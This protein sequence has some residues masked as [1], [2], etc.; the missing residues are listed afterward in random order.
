MSIYEHR[1]MDGKSENDQALYAITHVLRQVSSRHDV[2]N[3]IGPGTQTF[4]LLT[5]CYS[6]LTG[7][8]LAELR[9]SFNKPR[10]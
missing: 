5:E 9:K 8:P 1:L 2:R 3:V 4:D 10:S 6:S 7:E